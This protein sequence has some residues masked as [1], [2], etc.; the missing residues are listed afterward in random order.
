MSTRPS[1]MRPL[2]L[3]SGLAMLTY[4][5]FHLVN[6]SLGLISLDAAEAG[7]G[8]AKAI[9]RSWPGTVLLY[10]AAAVHFSLAAHCSW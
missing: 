1:L 6:H 5:F 2:R 9:W 7:L 4:L 3:A 8:I 10:G